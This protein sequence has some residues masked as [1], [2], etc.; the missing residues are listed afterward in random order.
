MKCVGIILVS[1]M[2]VASYDAATVTCRSDPTTD[3]DQQAVDDGDTFTLTCDLT[4]TGN[5]NNDH[6]ESCS[7]NHY[8]P[9]NEDRG[10]T[11]VPD[12]ECA[13]ALSGQSSNCPSDTRI[14]GTVN[15][16]SCSI[17]VSNSKPEDTGV[18]EAK[19]STVRLITQNISLY[20]III[21]N[22]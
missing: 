20:N 13:Y 16:G 1:S 6:V 22:Y 4:N 11:Y 3:E 15:T 18:W 19:I 12:I 5:N 14:T 9:L 21:L 2:L 8:E 17:Q 7:W 10:N